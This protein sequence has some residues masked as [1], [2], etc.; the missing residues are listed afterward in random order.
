MRKYIEAKSI[1]I[2]KPTVKFLKDIC[3]E[4]KFNPNEMFLY[5]EN[6]S[7]FVGFTSDENFHL[8]LSDDNWIPVYDC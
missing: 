1:K 3:K 4:R 2:K 7:L 8:E 5:M 6:N